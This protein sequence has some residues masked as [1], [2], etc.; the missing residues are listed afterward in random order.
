MLIVNK[1]FYLILVLKYAERPPHYYCPQTFHLV[2]Y[3]FDPDCSISL[4]FKESFIVFVFLILDKSCKIEVMFCI[5]GNILFSSSSS[6]ESISVNGT[7]HGQE[8]S[9]DSV[10]SE[11]SGS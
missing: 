4:S 10:S 3:G 2:L 8:F 11:A 6:Q 9:K 1:N 7:Y 5:A